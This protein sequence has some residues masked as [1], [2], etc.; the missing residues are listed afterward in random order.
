MIT[1]AIFKKKI[2]QVALL[3]LFAAAILAGPLIIIQPAEISAQANPCS[4]LSG[5]ARTRCTAAVAACRRNNPPNSPPLQQCIARAQTGQAAAAGTNAIF[6]AKK[7]KK[8]E[9]EAAVRSCTTS[10]CITTRAGRFT[11]VYAACQDRPNPQNCHQRVAEGCRGLT[12]EEAR[13]CRQEVAVAPDKAGEVSLDTGTDKPYTCGS[14]ANAV[15]TRF[16]LGC[17][18]KGGPIED[19]FYSIIRC[20]SVGIGLVLVASII[21]AGIQYASSTGNPDQT[22]A[23]KKRIQNAFVALIFYLLIFVMIQYL[24]P[25]GL[26]KN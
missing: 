11:N 16:N 10:A 19:L 5:A 24:V 25:G 1:A 17:Q 8:T 3:A 23:A 9:C 15:K 20:L 13:Q 7:I 14:G 12:G 2:F 4:Q 6:C 18:G 26:F 22:S 21:Y